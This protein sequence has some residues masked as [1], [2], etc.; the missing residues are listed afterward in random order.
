MLGLACSVR[1]VRQLTA[2]LEGLSMMVSSLE[3]QLLDREA[4]VEG[5]RRRIEA[6]GDG[7][8][9]EKELSRQVGRSVA[10][11]QGAGWGT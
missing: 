1:S 5:L 11:V 4:E 6:R 9:I 3:R 2:E 10:V 8:V 7:T